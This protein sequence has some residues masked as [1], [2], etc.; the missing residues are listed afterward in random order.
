MFTRYFGDYLGYVSSLVLIKVIV[1]HS[2]T[3]NNVNTKKKKLKMVAVCKNNVSNLSKTRM[4]GRSLGKPYL[5]VVFWR[6]F[7][8]TSK[9]DPVIDKLTPY[10]VSK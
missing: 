2:L 3:S 9:Q 4:F 5:R 10:F 7:E 8:L 6:F 1:Y